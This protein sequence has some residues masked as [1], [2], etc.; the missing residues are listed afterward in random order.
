MFGEQ[1]V[2][3][4]LGPA[5]PARDTAVAPPRLWAHDL[6]A[7]AERTPAPVARRW[8][9]RPTRRLVLTAGAAAV[10]AAATTVIY[11]TSTLD[12]SKTPPPE[13]LG[14]VLV[15]I[16]YEFP[17]AAPPAGPQLRA[18]AGRIGDASY[19]NHTGRYTYH[20]FKS[21]GAGVLGSGHGRTA[22]LSEERKIWEAAD[23]SGKQITI[24]LEPQYPDQESRD[25]WERVMRATPIP[26]L[27]P[28]SGPEIM[29]LTPFPQAPLPTDRAGLMEMLKVQF[30]G[31]AASKEVGTVYGRYAVP[32][33]TRAEIL[34]ILAGMPGFRWR[35]KVTDRAG[36]P[37]LAITFDDREHNVRFLL[38]FNPKTG[39]L[40]ADELLWLEPGQPSAYR[41]Y[42]DT[43]RTDSVG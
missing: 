42:L 11:E 19:E 29:Q 31:G 12:R 2:R 37:G 9:A 5:D 7:R 36:R 24:F 33:Q 43:G 28:K 41:L 13:A 18:L 25:Y 26:A 16:S 4:L 10:A 17:T 3:T 6:I 40:V 34:R 14:S 8:Y 23:G 30:G 27:D 35:G 32:R 1:Q 22:A 21:W 20:H 39:E 38:I 15:P